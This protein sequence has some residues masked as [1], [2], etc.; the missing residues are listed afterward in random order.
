VLGFISLTC[1]QI[2]D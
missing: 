1:Y 2:D